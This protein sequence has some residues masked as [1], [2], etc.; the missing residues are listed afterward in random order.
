ME[1]NRENLKLLPFVAV[2]LVKALGEVV[3]RPLIEDH[4]TQRE[5]KE[6]VKA[7]ITYFSSEE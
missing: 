3:I 7:S 6:P 1:L 5:P 4:L 2:G